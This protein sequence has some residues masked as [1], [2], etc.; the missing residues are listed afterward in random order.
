MQFETLHADE[1]SRDFSLP[2]E[3][4]NEIE[5]DKPSENEDNQINT[6]LDNKQIKEYYEEYRKQPKYLRDYLNSKYKSLDIKFD[7]NFIHGNANVNNFLKNNQYFSH[8]GFIHK[9]EINHDNLIKMGIF[10]YD[11][12]ITLYVHDYHVDE[13]FYDLINK[14]KVKAQ[15]FLVKRANQCLEL[16][17]KNKNTLKK[18][19]DEI[20]Q[21]NK[22]LYGDRIGFNKLPVHVETNKKK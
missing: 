3:P 13:Q 6:N 14:D 9:N 15:E 11:L 4:S 12:Y 2:P 22:R 20:F 16:A 7:K 19:H 8:N 17:Y 10:Y 5:M 18:L 21:I 1:P